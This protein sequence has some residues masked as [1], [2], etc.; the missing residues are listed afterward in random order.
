MLRINR[1]AAVTAAT[2]LVAPAGTAAA[3][4]DLRSPDA[5][6]AAAVVRQDLRSPDA[7][8]S[9]SRPVTPPPAVRVVEES[10][11]GG[12]EWGDAGIGAVGMLG[13]VLLSGGVALRVVHRRPRAPLAH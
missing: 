2:A 4:Q 10:S 12:F 9:A 8:D 1:L 6:D 5:R 11:S 3:A 7:R 13:V